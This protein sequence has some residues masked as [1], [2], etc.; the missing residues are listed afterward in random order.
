MNLNTC[1]NAH[2][3]HK[4]LAKNKKASRQK[5]IYRNKDQIFKLFKCLYLNR[6]ILFFILIN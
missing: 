5:L 3:M 6:N 2:I 1:L 4:I